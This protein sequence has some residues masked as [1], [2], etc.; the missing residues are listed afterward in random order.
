MK[1]SAA[2]T[3]VR[4]SSSCRCMV[5]RPFASFSYSSP[6]LPSL[7]SPT[8]PLMFVSPLLPLRLD[9]SS[10]LQLRSFASSPSSSSSDKT[11]EVHEDRSLFGRYGLAL[12]RASVSAGSLDKVFADLDM[13]NSLQAESPEFKLFIETPGI[14]AAEKLSVITAMKD[15]YGLHDIT[16]NFLKVLLENRRLGTLSKMIGSFE[17]YYRK[18]KGEI[19]CQV[20]SAKALT[21]GQEKEVV[22]ALQRRS[23]VKAKLIVEYQVQ[24]SIMGGLVVR[25]DERVLDFSVQSRVESVKAQMMGP[26]E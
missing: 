24:P 13:L 14:A 1:F 23:G 9:G 6:A 3:A 15:K 17:T 20:T 5:L 7:P 25:L 11:E 22:A 2:V 4:Q 21:S 19:K 12:F 16:V 10:S 8:S 26:V 18:H